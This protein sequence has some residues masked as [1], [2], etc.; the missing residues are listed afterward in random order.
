MKQLKTPR[1]P[2]KTELRELARLETRKLDPNGGPDA[3]D[4]KYMLD[5]AYIAVFDDYKEDG[6][7]NYKMYAG[8]YMLLVWSLRIISEYVWINDQIT[9]IDESNRHIIR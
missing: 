1:L 7:P 5:H 9:L 3:G 4:L 6:P 8:K 2:T